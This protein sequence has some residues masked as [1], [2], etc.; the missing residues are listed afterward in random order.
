[1]PDQQ[2]ISFLMFGTIAVVVVLAVVLLV[3]F[4]RKPS[5]RHSMRGEHE[6][7]IN[8]IRRDGPG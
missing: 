7:D 6:R 8:E 4:L 3:R 1:M 5:N 2:P